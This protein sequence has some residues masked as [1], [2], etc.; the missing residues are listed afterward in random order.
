MTNVWA[1]INDTGLPDCMPSASQKRY[2]LATVVTKRK[3]PA[4]PPLLLDMT[5]GWP[6]FPLD[7][8]ENSGLHEAQPIGS[9]FAVETE[10]R[11]KSGMQ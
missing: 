11:A 7:A 1:D 8:V 6:H 9:P 4:I 10:L 2:G 3:T 5:P